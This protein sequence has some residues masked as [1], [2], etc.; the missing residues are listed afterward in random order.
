MLSSHRPASQRTLRGNVHEPRTIDFLT[1]HCRDGD[2]VHAGAY[3][4]DFLPPL[5]RSCAAGAKIWAFEPLADN[6]RCA[7]ITMEINGIHNVVLTNAALGERQESLVMLT[8]DERGRPLGDANRILQQGAVASPATA[9]TVPVVA[10]DDVVPAERKVSIIHLDIEGHEQRALAGA[11]RTIER[12]SPI[13]VVETW[14]E[15]DWICN[16]I[17]RLGYRAVQELHMN[18][19]FTRE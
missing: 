8:V 3:F 4:G 17:Q 15:P 1:S 12:S 19:V 16:D 6:Y 18:T 10:I 9:K 14:Q 11:L 13:I 2:I 5:S 7:L